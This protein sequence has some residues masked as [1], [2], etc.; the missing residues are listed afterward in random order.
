MLSIPKEKTLNYP[1]RS[2]EQQDALEHLQH[3]PYASD[4]RPFNSISKFCLTGYEPVDVINKA[5]VDVQ[6]V[7]DNQWWY[8]ENI[9]QKRG[10]L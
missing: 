10:G 9:K 8:E 5:I 1:H 2:E 4:D 6:G 3:S 7:Q